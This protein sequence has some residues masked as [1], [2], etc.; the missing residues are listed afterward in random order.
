MEPRPTQAVCAL[1]TLK[2]GSV[3]RAREWAAHIAANHEQALQ[4]LAAESVTIESVFLHE[5]KDEAF[6]IYYMRSPSIARAQQ[7][8]RESA[9]AIERYHKEFKRDAWASVSRLELLL[10]LQQGEA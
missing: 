3:A 7:V 2:P 4:S 1:V 5:S 8:A 10:D 9:A 6:L